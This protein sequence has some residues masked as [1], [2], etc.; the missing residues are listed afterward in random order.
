MCKMVQIK[1]N[2]YQKS[3]CSW[4]TNPAKWR[5]GGLPSKK[6]Y[7]CDLPEH[8]GSLREE[9]GRINA[10]DDHYSEADYQTWMRL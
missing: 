2:T 8:K 9:I 10:L 3:T 5:I 4:C 1:P 6:F 7:S